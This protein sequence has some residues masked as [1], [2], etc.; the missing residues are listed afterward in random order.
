MSANN[1]LPVGAIEHPFSSGARISTEAFDL[2]LE[3][4]ETSKL[5]NLQ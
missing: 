3:R 5:S 2:V 4:F 1:K